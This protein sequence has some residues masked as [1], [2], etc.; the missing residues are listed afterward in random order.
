M[1]KNLIDNQEGTQ[2]TSIAK[3][4][5]ERLHLSFLKWNVGVSRKAS[6]A[7]IWG[8]TGRVPLLINVSKQ[9]FGYY[10][11]L[12]SMSADNEINCLVK[13]AFNEQRLL[14]MNWFKRINAL[15]TKLQS[16][17]EH[18]LQYPS[19]LRSKLGEV[20]KDIWR[21]ERLQNRKLTFYNSIKQS[22]ESEK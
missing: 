10:K 9:V 3:D 12:E 17:S 4:P 20:F 11:R 14:N 22:F 18:R 13:S 1:V 15:D 16:Q 6:N 19:Q 8:D 7:A 21:K 2:F 5:L